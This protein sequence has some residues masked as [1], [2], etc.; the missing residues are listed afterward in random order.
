[1]QP[2]TTARSAGVAAL[3]ALAVTDFLVMLDGLL[4][5]VIL[6]DI[7]RELGFSQ[8]DLGWVVTGYVLVFAGCML[9][10]GRIADLYGR[11]LL[12]LI[13]Y[14]LFGVGALLGGLADSAWMLIASRAI[15]GLGAAAMTPPGCRC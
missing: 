8:A 7:Q 15:Q 3:V 1:M 10:A 9:L 4:V 2:E 5:T 6:P 13:G 12:L 14:A 11:R